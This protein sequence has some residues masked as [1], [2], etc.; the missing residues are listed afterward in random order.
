VLIK[1]LTIVYIFFAKDFK[2]KYLQ[3]NPPNILS[4]KEQKKEEM[5][6]RIVVEKKMTDDEIIEKRNTYMTADMVPLENVVREDADVYRLDD[7]GVTEHL[8]FRFRKSSFFEEPGNEQARKNELTE[9]YKNII[10][11]MCTG[12]T[13]RG[14]T[15]G[16]KGNITKDSKRVNS[17]VIGYYDHLSMRQNSILKKSG[18]KLETG[19]RETRYTSQRPKRFQRLIPCIETIDRFYAQLVPE[20]YEK[21]VRK[22]NETEF[23]IAKTSFSTVSVNVNLQTTI[24]RDRRDDLEGFGNLSVIRKGEYTGGE[25]CFPQYGVG[26]DVQH[27]DICYMDTHQWHC[28]YPIVLSTPD[29]VRMSLVCY[30]MP[31]IWEETRG[32]PPGFLQQMKDVYNEA[33]LQQKNKKKSE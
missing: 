32:K 29:T 12:T 10:G 2:K 25:T 30:F 3:S 18:V 16:E 7:D 26:V 21:Q 6:L 14:N 17:V 23:R 5:V 28:N 22:A 19:V 31:K 15:T 20:A 4:L 13:A 27:G 9:F 24:H 1:T 33:R 8:L 11:F